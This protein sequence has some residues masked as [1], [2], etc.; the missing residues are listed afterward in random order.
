MEQ[1][2]VVHDV[3]VALD[4]AAHALEHLLFSLLL[5]KQHKENGASQRLKRDLSGSRQLDPEILI[6]TSAVSA[7][8]QHSPARTGLCCFACAGDGITERVDCGRKKLF[9]PKEVITAARELRPQE[10]ITAARGNYGR[11][12]E[13]RPQYRKAESNAAATVRLLRL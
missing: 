11:K 4:I 9:R 2:L 13:L 12:R 5:L 6:L 7:E 1:R 8:K 10:G 3:R